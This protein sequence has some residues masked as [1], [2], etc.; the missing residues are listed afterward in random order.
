MDDPRHIL[1]VGNPVDGFR[2]YGPFPDLQSAVE[3]S[4]RVDGDN[5]VSELLKADD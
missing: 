1:I 4:E 3:W 5:W 2:Y